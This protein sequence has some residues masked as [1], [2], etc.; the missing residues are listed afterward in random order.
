MFVSLASGVWMLREAR[1]RERGDPPG[2]WVAVFTYVVAGI[3]MK[4]NSR[5]Q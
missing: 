2:Y 5:S 1:R 3:R 4:L